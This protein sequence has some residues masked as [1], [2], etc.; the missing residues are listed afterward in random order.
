MR[1]CEKRRLFP[2][3]TFPCPQR[4]LTWPPE[5]STREEGKELR[6]DHP[7][8]PACL[9]R[10]PLSSVP[11]PMRPSPAM[12]LLRSLSRRSRSVTTPT[13]TTKHQ[14]PS[15]QQPPA[16]PSCP[17]RSDRPGA[18]SRQRGSRLAQ[19]P[20]SATSGRRATSAAKQVLW[21]DLGT[22]LPG[23]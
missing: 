1:L 21:W 15:P 9:P 13:N 6:P 19:G 12:P 10:E 16:A 14:K 18:W 23:N 2:L 22:F 17:P 20:G 3:A 5:Q 11:P 4:C 7:C 8:L